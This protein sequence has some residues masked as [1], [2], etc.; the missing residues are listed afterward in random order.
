[1][2]AEGQARQLLLIASEPGPSANILSLSGRSTFT[3]FSSEG[4]AARAAKGI[5]ATPKQMT[6][7]SRLRNIVILRQ[8]AMTSTNSTTLRM[9]PAGFQLGVSGCATPLL[10]VQRINKVYA[11]GAGSANCVCHCRNPYLPSSFPSCASRQLGPRSM[12]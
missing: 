12:E 10:L 9:K 11:P 4:V 6:A 8:T 5:D 2:S 1:M 3:D 7:G